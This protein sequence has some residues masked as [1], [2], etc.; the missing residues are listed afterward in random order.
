MMGR[1]ESGTRFGRDSG[2]IRNPRLPTKDGVR[3]LV[4][5]E[6]L[7]ASGGAEGLLKSPTGMPIPRR[8]TGVSQV[9]C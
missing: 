2:Q 4:S 5:A 9:S 7:V 8:L 1:A 3:M 6:A